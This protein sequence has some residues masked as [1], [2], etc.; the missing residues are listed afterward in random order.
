METIRVR[1]MTEIL[2]PVVEFR[3]YESSKILQRPPR[4]AGWQPEPIC[5]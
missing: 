2:S 4:S 1:E 3:L 5:F